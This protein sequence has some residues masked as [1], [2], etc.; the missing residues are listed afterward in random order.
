LAQTANDPNLTITTSSGIDLR[1][2]DPAI[3]GRLWAPD[4]YISDPHFYME[5]AALCE[6][7]VWRKEIK[8]QERMID[9]RRQVNNPIMEIELGG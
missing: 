5:E 9:R 6:Y 3:F 1:D 8:N 4:I 2:L 7:L